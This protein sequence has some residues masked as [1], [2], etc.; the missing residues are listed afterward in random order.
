MSRNSLTEAI[1]KLRSDDARVQN[2]GV[3][4]AIHIAKEAVPELILLLE[5]KAGEIRQQAMY[6]LAQ[7]SDPTACM[8]FEKGIQDSDERVRAYAAE[9]LVR[10]YHPNALSACL[11]TINDAPDILHLDITPAVGA[12]SDFGLKAVPALLEFLM[13]EDEMTRLHAQRALE[14]I[15]DKRHGFRPGKGFPTVEAEEQARAEWVNN[16]NYNYLE[17]KNT[18]RAAVEKLREWLV[19]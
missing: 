17:D 16:G 14:L 5:E 9:G 1:N 11:M 19:T 18:R 15:V 4:E 8:A 10:I 2:Q 12:L 13:H 6:A 3:E 7:I